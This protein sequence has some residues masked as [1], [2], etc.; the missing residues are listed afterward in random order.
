MVDGDDDD[1]G[2]D[3]WRWETMTVYV[4]RPETMRC[5]G[6]NLIRQRQNS[7]LVQATIKIAISDL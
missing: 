1:V 6:D 5:E 7:S 4:R 3:A 2:R